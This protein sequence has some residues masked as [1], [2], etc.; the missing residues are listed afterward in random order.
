MAMYRYTF[1][2]YIF[3][4]FLGGSQIRGSIKYNLQAEME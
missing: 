2:L 3:P 1:W 4:I